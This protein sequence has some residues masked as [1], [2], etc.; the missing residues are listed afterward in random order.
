MID[1][2]NPH[3]YALVYMLR[4]YLLSILIEMKYYY[5]KPWHSFSALN[6][7]VYP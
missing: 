2:Y 4:T 3:C 5:T 6:D 7:H 1:H